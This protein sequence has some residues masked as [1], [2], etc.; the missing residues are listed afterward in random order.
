[1]T[2]CSVNGVCC[3]GCTAGQF[4]DL[5][6]TGICQA[7]PPGHFSGSGQEAC[8]SCAAGHIAPSNGSSTCTPCAA[9]TH[10][11]GC[12]TVS[13]GAVAPGHG[14]FTGPDGSEFETVAGSIAPDTGL[15]C[16]FAVA[17]SN[18]VAGQHSAAAQ[19]TCIDCDAGTYAEAT[20]QS[21]CIACL[22]GKYL[23]T[24]G[25]TQ[26]S[27]CIDCDAGKYVETTG[28]TQ[29][30]DCAF[31]TAGNYTMTP[32]RATCRMCQAG[33]YTNTGTEVGA[34]Q[35]DPCSI[36]QST[37]NSTEN[38]AQERGLYGEI[39]LDVAIEELTADDRD[40]L[41]SAIAS[42]IATAV[43]VDLSRVRVGSFASGILH[44][45]AKRKKTDASSPPRL[46]QTNSASG[47][48]VVSFVIIPDSN[49][50][51]AKN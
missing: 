27:D 36:G 32:G 16:G 39:T 5:A 38:C 48:V 33:S 1:M 28:S 43:G 41:A 37:N 35:C 26:A 31:C 14:T 18:C 22:V 12:E 13:V 47:S 50:A 21:A 11:G 25:G 9:G 6:D 2:R 44:L 23:N 34:T 10:R 4:H 46:T 24:M 3:A 40:A 29:A 8:S 20:G 51:P 45:R 42:S 15:W 7:C 17:C 49:G 30:S 19:D